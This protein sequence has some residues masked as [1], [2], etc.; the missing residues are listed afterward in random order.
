MEVQVVELDSHPVVSQVD[1]KIGDETVA[2]LWVNAGG[3]LTV[4]PTLAGEGRIYL[5]D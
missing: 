4:C 3:N 2:R 1:V 5:V